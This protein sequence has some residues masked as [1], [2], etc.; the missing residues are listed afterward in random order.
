MVEVGVT[1]GPT[2][3]RRVS[4]MPG[5]EGAPRVEAP[6]WECVVA[7]L[8]GGAILIACVRVS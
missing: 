6:R 3:E 4:W 8:E 1:V 7:W 5:A 2:P